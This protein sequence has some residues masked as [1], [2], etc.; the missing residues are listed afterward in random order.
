MSPQT[1][2]PTAPGR[3]LAG[4][5]TV[6][7]VIGRGGIADVHAGHDTRT[8][9]A[10]A[11]KA[12]RVTSAGDPLL[13]SGLRREAQVLARVRHPSVVELLDAGNEGDG[14]TDPDGA[15]GADGGPYIVMERVDGRSLRELIR[16]GEL[17]RETSVRY[18]LGVLAALEASHR[19]GIVH[20]DVKPANVMVTASGA[21]KLVDF[22]IARA[23]GDPTVTVTRIQEFLGTPAYFSPEQARGGTT[24]ARSDVYSAGCLLFE[25]L[26][27][28]P[29]FVGDD[30]VL[31][32]YQHVYEP[33]PGAGT[34]VPGLDA[35]IAKALAKNPDER[36]LSAGAFQNALLCATEPDP[37][38]TRERGSRPWE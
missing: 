34:G 13:R 8:G 9:R 12:L 38:D 25:M 10:V 5:Y 32:A 14:G 28:R 35:V 19:A 30:P 4:R 6:A 11:I 20:R 23:S 26:T 31:V 22:G 37:T 16:A 17:T 3:V 36:F 2:T 7:E 18:L 21:V 24:D 1:T 29:P 15:D 33:A 27:G